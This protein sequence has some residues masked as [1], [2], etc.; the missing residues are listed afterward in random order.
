MVGRNYKAPD[1]IDSRMLEPKHAFRQ[2][3]DV[4]GQSERS[5]VAV[6]A[7]QPRAYERFDVIGCADGTVEDKQVQDCDVDIQSKWL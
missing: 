1:F 3:Y 6:V 2:D 4:E 5:N 7:T